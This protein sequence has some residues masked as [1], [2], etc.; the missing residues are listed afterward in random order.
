MTR[1]THI[2][3]HR[4]AA[5][6]PRATN[7]SPDV[8]KETLARR[9]TGCAAVSSVLPAVGRRKVQLLSPFIFLLIG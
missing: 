6:E 5:N 1:R 9:C 3:L 4:H 2:P 7:G 8:A